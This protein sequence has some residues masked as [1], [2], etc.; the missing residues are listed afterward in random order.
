MGCARFGFCRLCLATVD[1]ERV[2]YFQRVHLLHHD[3]WCNFRSIQLSL[4]DYLAWIDSAGDRGLLRG[5]GGA[6]ESRANNGPLWYE[7]VRNA[8][9]SF[10]GNNLRR[11]AGAIGVCLI[12]CACLVCASLVYAQQ[13]P[14][15]PD[16]A[17]HSWARFGPRAWKVVR[18]KTDSFDDKGQVERTST[19]TTRMQ[20][21]RVTRRSYSL[22]VSSTAEVSGNHIMPE[23]QT[24]TQNLDQNVILSQTLKSQTLTIGNREYIANVVRVVTQNGNVVRTS[25][26]YYSQHAV[27][28]VLKRKTIST[29]AQ[30]HDIISETTVDVTEVDHRRE[31][32]GELLSTWTVSIVFKQD[33]AVTITREVHC[34]DVPGELVSRETEKRDSSGQI[35]VRDEL[36][37]V[38]YGY[39]LM[40]RAWRRYR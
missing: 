37:L 32:L 40:R 17:S 24:V 11:V 26:I 20:V 8:M 16:L 3:G 34:Q 19:R 13:V 38:G 21:T 30:T 14:G 25:T 31:I 18:V 9:C 6:L 22:C 29:N 1:S 27:P 33:G 2:R 15:V 23:P 5:G 7:A 35:Q 12:V 39:G 4:K 28:E 36:E 10:F